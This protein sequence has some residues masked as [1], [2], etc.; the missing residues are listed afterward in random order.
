ML[1][2][3]LASLALAL[4]APLPADGDD[5]HRQF[6]FWIGEWSV[7]NRHI[8]PDGSWKDGDVTRARIVPVC[9][10]K[11]VLE[12]W[13]GP[14]RGTFMNGFSL[15]AYDPVRKDWNLLLFWTTNGDASFGRLR[16]SFRHGRG[17]FFSSWKDATGKD[18][19]Q[20]YTFSD[21][22][23]SSVRWDSATTKDGGKSWATDWIMEFSRTRDASE[24]TQ[25]ELFDV[26]WTEG[27]LS[28]HP[29]ARRLDWL[30]GTWKG[31]QKLADGRELEA[32]LRCKLL[33]KDCLVL[34][35]LETR[36][37]GIGDWN[38]RL[39]VRGFVPGA[40]A[41]ESW[42]LS[43][44]DTVLRRS[45]G[46]LDADRAV[47]ERADA[48]SGVTVREVF[49]RTGSDSATVVYEVQADGGEPRVVTETT[50]RREE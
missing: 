29:E 11:A 18:V 8:Q 12:E 50:L 39:C 19:T 24:V 41:W 30:L 13:A 3:L 48:A 49:V 20:R 21:G 38:E 15:R 32:R 9:G 42:G 23:P 6:D 7:Q 37:R 22:L 36:P 33:D 17:E 1:T 26:A 34:D 28:P 16:G 31:V 45:V 35:L 43:E 40:G 14:F 2:P 44:R 47:F 46:T 5:P 27:S 10:G 25:D 4:P